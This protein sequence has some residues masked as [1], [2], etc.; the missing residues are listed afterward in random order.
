M[1]HH[2]GRASLSRRVAALAAVSVVVS[3]SALS[4]AVAPASPRSLGAGAAEPLVL[5][6]PADRS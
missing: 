4:M 6:K 3:V 5:R 2:G 1:Q